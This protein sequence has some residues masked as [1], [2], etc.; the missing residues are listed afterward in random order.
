MLKGN[1]NNW[2]KV[3][4]KNKQRLKKYLN[5]IEKNGYKINRQNCTNR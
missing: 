4:E 3:I 2:K 5:K 1:N